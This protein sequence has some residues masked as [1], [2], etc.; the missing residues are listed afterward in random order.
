MHSQSA[1]LTERE[2]KRGEG[3]VENTHMEK[4]GI[5]ERA[6]KRNGG[7]DADTERE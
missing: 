3:G 7:G 1:N 6:R 4:R 5:G 2:R